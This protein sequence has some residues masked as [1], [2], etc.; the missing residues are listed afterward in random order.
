MNEFGTELSNFEPLS[1]CFENTILSHMIATTLVPRKI[2]PSS[3]STKELVVLYCIVKKYCLNLYD[4]FKNLCWKVIR[5]LFQLLDC[6][7]LL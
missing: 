6:L 3:I 1:L 2:S 5:I 7:T 4:G